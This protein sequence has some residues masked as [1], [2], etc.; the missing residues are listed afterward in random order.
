MSGSLEVLVAKGVINKSQAQ[1]I[2]EYAER[3][4]VRVEEALIVGGIVP[5]AQLLKLLA[6]HYRTR[7]IGTP[8]LKQIAVK[9][10][11][12]NLIPEAIAID[13]HCIPILYDRN[14]QTLTV[15]TGRSDAIDVVERE[16]I[17]ASNIKRIRV[18]IA[19]PAA[20]DAAIRKCYRG[21]Q[22]AFDS[23][24][25]GKDPIL[26][27]GIGQA[28]SFGQSMPPAA[29]SMGDIPM[30]VPAAVPVAAQ[31]AAP[32][33]AVKEPQAALPAIDDAA[34]FKGLA[35]LT[36][37]KESMP[38][39]AAPVPDA[40][41]A[42]P[43]VPA[44]SAAPSLTPAKRN[45]SLEGFASVFVALL[46]GERG[47]LR[48]HSG[49]VARLVRDLGMRMGMR[50]AEL[51]ACALAA[52]LH[53][54]GKPMSY[55]L[56][57]VNVAR[58]EGHR[59]AAEKTYLAPQRI[60]EQAKLP[61]GA[62]D[63]LAA[64]YEKWDGSGFPDRLRAKDIPLGARLLALSESYVDVTTNPKNPWRDKLTPSAAVE[65]L[66]PYSGAIF[67]PTLFK[68]LENEVAGNT[69]TSGSDAR[70]LVI[71]TDLED[72]IVL[73]LR[74]AEAGYD[75]IVA[76]SPDEAKE[77]MAQDPKLIISEV[78]ILGS[79]DGFELV[80]SLAPSVP[81]VFLSREQGPDHVSRGFE[82]GASDYITKP[83][84][85]AVIVQKIS[86][87]LKVAKS[88]ASFSGSIQEMPLVEVVQ[89]VSNSRK[90]GRLN[91]S[92]SDAAGVDGSG[93][94]DFLQGSVASAK[95]QALQGADA[96]FAII[97]LEKGS[98]G[99]DA[100]A[101]LDPQTIHDST[102]SLLLEALRRMDEGL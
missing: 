31:P 13:I 85:G 38:Q 55:H 10:G 11:L 93:Y 48:G 1:F 52:Q 53:D 5:E 67:D 15:V 54:V 32:P 17:L 51:E 96:F 14:T 42:Q 56:T 33:T 66:S 46:E 90:T 19:R 83:I 39:K 76:R 57:A 79:G 65:A 3:D 97:R 71:D 25:F 69:R 87:L 22:Y 95:W 72:T 64:M 100:S 70:V 24:E 36:P 29:T 37:E 91:L 99:L 63:T 40:L 23:L 50:A 34:L 20:V 94:L 21:D 41:I 9:K 92:G 75:V 12:L 81:F 44:N 7:F 74:L 2:K 60:F 47:D 73:E 8:K 49:R 102:E 27:A 77:A 101:S 59:I 84:V 61:T 82:L 98:F 68:L 86:K 35:N 43:D 62:T 89:V 58:F 6:S 45:V 4:S 78:N 30:D 88:S 16:A 28:G 18:F 80:E 26:A